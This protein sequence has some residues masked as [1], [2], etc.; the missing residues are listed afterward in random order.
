MRNLGELLLL[1]KENFGNEEYDR[2]CLCWC[3]DDMRDKKI[4]SGHEHHKVTNHIRVHKPTR[5]ENPDS[6]FGWPPYMI[7]VRKKWIDE[8]VETLN[9]I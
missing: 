4:I 5:A 1:L 3:A 7:D 8:Q 2:T 6:G 9:H